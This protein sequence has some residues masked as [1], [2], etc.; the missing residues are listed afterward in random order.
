MPARAGARTSS[1]RGLAE[2][3]RRRCDRS[4]RTDVR[5]RELL[6]RGGAREARRRRP[7]RRPPR[8]GRIRICLFKERFARGHAS[9]SAS[10]RRRRRRR[11]RSTR[12]SAPPTRWAIRSCSSRA[13]TPASG[14][15]RGVV[16][17]SR[18]AGGEFEPYPIG[19]GSTPCCA[20]TPTS[21][22][23]I[24]SATT[25]SARSMSSASRAVSTATGPCWPSATAARCSQSPRRLGVGTMFEPIAEQPFT[26]AAVDAVR[27]V[28]V[29]A[30]SSSRCS[31]TGR[32]GRVLGRR[33][34]PPRLRAD[35][36]RHRARQRPPG[37]V[38]PSRSRATDCRRRGP[39]LGRRG[40]GTTRSPP[41]SGSPFASSVVR[42]RGGH[43]SATPRADAHAERRRDVRRG[44]IRC[45]A[46]VFGLGTSATRGRS[47]GRSSSTPRSPDASE[48]P[49]GRG[50]W[51]RQGDRQ[52]CASGSRR[53]AKER[54]GPLVAG[55]QPTRVDLPRRTWGLSVGPNG[56]LWS[57]AVDLHELA[58]R[59]GRRCTSCAPSGSTRNA[60]RHAERAGRRRHLLL[61][62]DEPRPG[63]A[64]APARP[65][66]RRRGHLAL[67][68]VARLPA[69]RARR[70]DHLQRPGQV[71]RLDPQGDP[72]GVLLINANSAARRR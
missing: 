33:P 1:S 46:C 71:A 68:A 61:L 3:D 34:Q 57:G 54:V 4:R 13:P 41:T 37:A 48:R 11:H 65:R 59:E 18:R 16:A 20:T 7:R 42:D 5:L 39:A 32:T 6:C 27:A 58:R 35:L 19:P 10:R 60:A 26:D 70:A 25:S 43:R 56:T 31:S 38:V 44:A 51:P 55:R 69:R 12:R 8:P 30:C 49:R 28:L 21:P 62:Q 53:V 66:C 22:C 17:R 47:S 23:P 67:R 2:R 52:R 24:C 50:A 72:H 64:A 9:T 29:R 14:R 36:A 15:S 63:G 40:S 45:R